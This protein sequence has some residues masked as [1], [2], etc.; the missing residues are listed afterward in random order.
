MSVKRIPFKQQPEFRGIPNLFTV[1]NGV[2]IQGVTV[3]EQDKVVMGKRPGWERWLKLDNMT[4]PFVYRNNIVH[5]AKVTGF[6]GQR[7]KFYL[8][9]ADREPFPQDICVLVQTGIDGVKKT[10]YPHKC[11]SLSGAIMLE[12][13]DTLGTDGKIISREEFWSIADGGA[14]GIIFANGT[15]KVLRRKALSVTLVDDP[16]F[17]ERMVREHRAAEEAQ[18]IDAAL[19]LAEQFP[20]N[21]TRAEI[22]EFG[23][24]VKNNLAREV[25]FSAI[26][27]TIMDIVG[28]VSGRK[29]DKFEC[30]LLYTL[31]NHAD[32]GRMAIEVGDFVRGLHV[33]NP[34]PL[35]VMEKLAPPNG[36]EASHSPERLK[37]EARRAALRAERLEQ[38]PAKGKAG[39]KPNLGADARMRRE[40]EQAA[41]KA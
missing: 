34:V 41:K 10:K 23:E 12:G 21:L 22:E 11:I 5:R 13:G 38:A 2:L 27:D 30:Y 39:T 6:Q 29:W 19:R 1:E 4:P 40:H 3:V 26:C 36:R 32:R 18:T 35:G 16:N 8:L 31:V 17:T 37:R 24:K 15:T 20:G 9:Q 7:S 33:K 25:F 28:G 14:L